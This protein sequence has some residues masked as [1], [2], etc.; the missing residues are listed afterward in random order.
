MGSRCLPT[1]FSAQVS[2]GARF[3]G[4]RKY[5]R[6]DDIEPRRRRWQMDFRCLSSGAMPIVKGIVVNVLESSFCHDIVEY[7]KNLAKRCLLPPS[8]REGALIAEKKFYSEASIVPEL[9]GIPL[10]V[11][12]NPNHVPT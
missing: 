7:T 12:K 6:R 4:Y 3:A 11:T 10:S 8:P 1:S 2:Q 9:F 5:F